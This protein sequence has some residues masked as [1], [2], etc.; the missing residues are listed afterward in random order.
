MGTLNE[1]IDQMRELVQGAYDRG[2]WFAWFLGSFALLAWRLA[3]WA[4][5]R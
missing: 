2:D 1:D 4:G 5:M 3:R